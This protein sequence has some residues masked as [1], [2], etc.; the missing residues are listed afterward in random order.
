MVESYKLTAK[1]ILLL[2]SNQLVQMFED[3]ADKRVPAGNTEIGNR[4]KAAVRYAWATLQARAV[5]AVGDCRHV[6]PFSHQEFG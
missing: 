5:M 2:L 3:L 4:P 6:H 1:Q